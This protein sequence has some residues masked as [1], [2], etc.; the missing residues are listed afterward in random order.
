MLS[1]NRPSSSFG[2]SNTGDMQ[3]QAL[4]ERKWWDCESKTRAFTTPALSERECACAKV[5]INRMDADPTCA[6]KSLPDRS[7]VFEGVRQE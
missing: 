1:S 4:E 5:E 7:D 6:G 2:V 3:L